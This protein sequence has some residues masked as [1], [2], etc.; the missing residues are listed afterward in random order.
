MQNQASEHFSFREILH[1]WRNEIRNIFGDFGVMLIFIFAAMGY[2]LL[3]AYAY[4]TEVL[5]DTP[6]AVVDLD[7]SSMSRQLTRMVDATEE[8]KVTANPG[9]LAEAQKLL[10]AG[11]VDGI[12]LLPEDFSA[13][14]FR[15]EQAAVVVYAD[16]SYFLNYKQVLKATS[17]ATGT[18]SAGLQIRQAMAKGAI[19]DQA[20]AGATPLGLVAT[21]LY[22]PSGGY[23]TYVMPAV[24]L[25]VLQQTL[26]IGIGMLGGTQH[27]R[28]AFRFIMPENHS[29]KGLLNIIIGKASA[30]FSVYFLH[31]FY[32][33]AF[34]PWLFTFPQRAPLP[35]VMLFIIPF[36]L[37]VA[38][39]GLTLVSFFKTR[40]HSIMFL[41]FLSMPFIFLSGI[42]WPLEAF[43]AFW[44]GVAQLV[45]ST[46]AIQG[47]LKINNMGASFQAVSREW[48][49]LWG[50]S[51]LF[52]FTAWLSFYRIS[53]KLRNE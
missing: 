36:I 22:N 25:L 16:A 32:L 26:L 46:H 44:K 31:G 35:Q 30:Y 13:S 38:F 48:I 37:S 24:L 5:R 17:Y 8:I 29:A 3:Y 39:M 19:F 7:G 50:M 21:P 53:R 27:E 49:T 34:I 9:S 10:Y 6:V 14:I 51:A 43:P 12:F 52:F 40:V 28:N 15:K 45:P 2:P 1:I 20:K 41:I 23:A 18:L 42:S 33:F 11:K 47:F 4:S